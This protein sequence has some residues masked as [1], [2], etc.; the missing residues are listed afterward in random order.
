MESESESTES[1]GEIHS[2]PGP[3]P[4]PDPGEE[5]PAPGPDLSRRRLLK[6]TAGASV[7]A[8]GV[9]AGATLP[10]ELELIG[11]AD[12][13]G[14]T[15]G[16]IAGGVAFGAGVAIGNA[17]EGDDAELENTNNMEDRV[18][19]AAASIASQHNYDDLRQNV[20]K[21]PKKEAPLYRSAWNDA[22][23]AAARTVLSGGTDSEA[24][25][26]WKHAVDRH[27][28]RV[29]FNIA[30]SY[31]QL[32]LGDDSSTGLMAPL[33]LSQSAGTNQ[34]Q[35]N[36]TSA[37]PRLFKAQPPNYTAGGGWESV[38]ASEKFGSWPPSSGSC[39]TSKIDG[40]ACP[41]SDQYGLFVVETT[42]TSD[43][44]AFGRIRDD[45]EERTGDKTVQIYGPSTGS[46][47]YPLMQHIKA[48]S[49]GGST[50]SNP[51]WKSFGAY[52]NVGGDGPIE[53]THPSNST[54]TIV[55]GDIHG[56][57]F[58][59]ALDS[60]YTALTDTGTDAENYLL[61]VLAPGL[62]SGEITESE[63]FSSRDL[64][65]QYSTDDS[66]QSQV[67]AASAAVGAALPEGTGTEVKINH[68]K[69]ESEG[70]T[71]PTDPNKPDGLWSNTF[72]QFS[73]TA[74]GKQSQTITTGST[75]PKA[76]YNAAYTVLTLPDG[77][78]ETMVLPGDSDL[79]ILESEAGSETTWEDQA[80]NPLDGNAT[81][82]EEELRDRLTS[83][84][85]TDKEIQDKLDDSGSV[86]GG[87]GG[88]L[89]D[90]LPT[91]PGLGAVGTVAAVVAGFLG[92]SAL[93]S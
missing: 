50:Y 23:V 36:P 59:S 75:I 54:V 9:G 78:T 22:E 81:L 19:N 30:Q 92:L 71:D 77:S 69:L 10:G 1:S 41:S 6:T 8:A 2:E 90:G 15:A 61:N 14:L 47:T 5:L 66:E 74:A 18:Y 35:F 76:D 68:N 12:A 56:S 73:G 34:L 29:R 21:P 45:I 46:T 82:T 87:A 79:K 57:Q 27:F 33:I 64:I 31:N 44:D 88:N 65:E 85:E 20:M 25:T 67:A 37:S 83:M 53:C 43:T 3:G 91:L 51:P 52:L 72:I 49:I 17:L 4:G 80:P 62:R 7:A 86:L 93:S 16:V 24:W 55:P 32:W 70:L 11:D 89:L 84:S 58:T 48:N 26:A 42:P 38:E 63:V 60:I 13:L 28:Q 39:D 40:Y